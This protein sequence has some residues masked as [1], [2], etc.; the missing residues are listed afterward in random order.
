MGERYRFAPWFR[1][2]MSSEGST[3]NDWG[4]FDVWRHTAE[5]GVR[6]PLTETLRL[7]A[8]A[9]YSFVTGGDKYDNSD[10]WI[11]EMGL[12]HEFGP[13]TRHSLFMGNVIDYDDFG[14]SR[15][16]KYMRYTID[17]VLG[18]R[19]RARAFIQGAEIDES[20]DDTRNELRTGGTLTW[21]VFD[22]T[23]LT[24]SVVYAQTDSDRRDGVDYERWIYRAT[25]AHR[26]VPGLFGS[27]T[28]QYEDYTEENDAYFDEHL[29]ILTLTKTF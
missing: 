5:T 4:T 11:Y 8:K 28:Y 14:D 15:I 29:I 26:I 25:L 3:D 22:F 12:I 6:G 18:P 20:G 23:R 1:Y 2:S 27:A 19:L 9:G 16:A 21:N 17:Q 10:S 24:G 13:Y 7:Q